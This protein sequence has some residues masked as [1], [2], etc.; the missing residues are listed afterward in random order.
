MREREGEGG[1][2]HISSDSCGFSRERERERGCVCVCVCVG[3]GV[4]SAQ[5]L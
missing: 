1:V 5:R 3:G 2:L 4:L